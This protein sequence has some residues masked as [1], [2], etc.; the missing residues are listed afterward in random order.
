MESTDEPTP[1]SINHQCSADQN[2]TEHWC[3][4]QSKEIIPTLTSN[5]KQ[6]LIKTQ[7][8]FSIP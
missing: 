7:F 5:Q 4:Q 1:S 2:S 8:L 6:S 3:Y